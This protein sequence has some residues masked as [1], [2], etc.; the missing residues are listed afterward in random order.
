MKSQDNLKLYVLLEYVKSSKFN[1]N[2]KILIFN[3]SINF[4]N[5]NNNY[6][7]N[8]KKNQMIE[9]LFGILILMVILVKLL[10]QIGMRNVIV[11]ILQ[12]YNLL[13]KKICILQLEN[14]I[15]QFSYQY[16]LKLVMNLIRFIDMFMMFQNKLKMDGYINRNMK[17]IH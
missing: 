7:K 8:F 12:F 11:L 14:G 13:L 10:L 1:I 15:K 9:K 16:Q 4:I 2:Q 17:F 5:G 3:F 6:Q